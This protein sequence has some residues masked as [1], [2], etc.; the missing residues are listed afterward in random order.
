MVQLVISSIPAG[1]KESANK[2]EWYTETN[3]GCLFHCLVLVVLE[4][5]RVWYK[6]S[7]KQ[8]GKIV[9]VAYCIIPC[10]AANPANCERCL[11]NINKM[12][13]KKK[14]IMVQPPFQLLK[15]A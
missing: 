5:E 12:I 14:N 7:D 8:S 4:Y 2:G 15:E 13:I 9:T 10:V 3:A 11:Q 6:S 1:L